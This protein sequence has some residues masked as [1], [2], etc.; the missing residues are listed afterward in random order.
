MSSDS[1][2]ESETEEVLHDREAAIQAGR[3]AARALNTG[4]DRDSE[5]FD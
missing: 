4:D 3:R 1:T 2:A 5:V